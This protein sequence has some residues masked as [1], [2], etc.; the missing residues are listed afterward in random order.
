MSYSRME[1]WPR[2]QSFGITNG[3]M[4]RDVNPLGCKSRTSLLNFAR[5]HAWQHE[6]LLALRVVDSGRLTPFGQIV[7]DARWGGVQRVRVSYRDAPLSG[8]FRCWVDGGLHWGDGRDLFVGAAWQNRPG[9][10]VLQTRFSK[11][12]QPGLEV[13]SDRLFAAN[14]GL[15]RSTD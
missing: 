1:R 9:R 6:L 7:W 3:R 14:A 15:S 13:S 8:K 4:V 5:S 10:W 12:P 2:L 11:S